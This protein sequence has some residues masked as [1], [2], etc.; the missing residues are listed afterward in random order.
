MPEETSFNGLTS[1]A[2]GPGQPIIKST[3]E[4][5]MALYQARIKAA[6]ELCPELGIDAAKEPKQIFFDLTNLN[7]LLTALLSGSKHLASCLGLTVLDAEGNPTTPTPEQLVLMQELVDLQAAGNYAGY[8]EKIQNI[9]LG[10]TV[11][12]AGCDD[13]GNLNV[14]ETGV[15]SFYDMGGY[16]CRD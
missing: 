5:M 11:L 10:Q 3:G 8:K 4:L 13:H 7:A 9:S 15:Y 16:C 2:S 6:T 14:H 12:I 1:P